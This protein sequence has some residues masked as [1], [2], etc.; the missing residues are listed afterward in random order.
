MSTKTVYAVITDRII[1]ALESGTVPWRAPWRTIKPRSLA[2]GSNYRGI[3][4]LMLELA[5]RVEGYASPYWLTF[6]QAL[7]QGGNVRK[8]AKG[9]PCLFFK[10][11]SNDDSADG[12]PEADTSDNK[13]SHVI[14]R[15]YTVFNLDQCEG[16]TAPAT[17]EIQPFN[18]IEACEMVVS[19][20]ESRGPAVR[21]GGNR[22][23]YFPQADRVDMPLPQQFETP[24]AFY[25]TLFHEL[26]HSTGH[27]SRLARF[28]STSSVSPF[29]SESYS[30]EEL[31]AELTA[32]FLCAEAGI[33][34]PVIQEQAAYVAGW[35]ARLREDSRAVITAA[36]Q[37]QKASDLILA[38]GCSA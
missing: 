17:E 8:G 7:A 16:V 36:A 18:P 21:L 35:L 9:W 5:T 12:A 33:S 32:A 31:V 20:Y 38:I 11:V 26:G 4:C 3:N 13:R 25:G 27:P 37:A 34:P 6:R 14:A 1:Q 29:G 10:S 24:A 2:T 22:A 28:E 30:R 15:Y 23:C 19:G